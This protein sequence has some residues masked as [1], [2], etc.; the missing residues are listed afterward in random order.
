MR[1]L[2]ECISFRQKLRSCPF[3]KGFCPAK[4]GIQTFAENAW[5]QRLITDVKPHANKQGSVGHAGMSSLPLW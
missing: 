1:K 4:E 3:S 5:A 2:A